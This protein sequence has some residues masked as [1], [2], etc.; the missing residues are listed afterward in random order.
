MGALHQHTFG[1]DDL[2]LSRKPQFTV[3]PFVDAKTIGRNCENIIFYA[4]GQ[5][6]LL[7]V[8]ENQI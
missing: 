8:V 4:A 5:H 2:A 7:A 3:G 6:S 1:G